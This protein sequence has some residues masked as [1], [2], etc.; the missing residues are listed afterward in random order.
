MSKRKG[1]SVFQF[2]SPETSLCKRKVDLFLSFAY[3]IDFFKQKKKIVRV[4]LNKSSRGSSSSGS[5]GTNRSADV[6][7]IICLTACVF[8][9][10]KKGVVEGEAQLPARGGLGRGGDPPICKLLTFIASF[11]RGFNRA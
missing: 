9:L 3:P 8:G 6:S 1:Q 11:I 10:L 2:H 5:S 4:R 7:N